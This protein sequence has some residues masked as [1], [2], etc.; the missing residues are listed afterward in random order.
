MVK[1][2]DGNRVKIQLQKGSGSASAVH[3]KQNAGE[4]ETTATN[5]GV[6]SFGQEGQTEDEMKAQFSNM[7]VAQFNAMRNCFESMS[8]NSPM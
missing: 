7:T 8:D 6:Q 2:Q 1:V 3:A 5:N 4:T